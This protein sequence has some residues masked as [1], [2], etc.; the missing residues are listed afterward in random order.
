[1][2]DKRGVHR[3]QVDVLKEEKRE[4]RGMRRGRCKWGGENIEPL[5]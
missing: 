1:M 4:V 5:V 2:G 3:K